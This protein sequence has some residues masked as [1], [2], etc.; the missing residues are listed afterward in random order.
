MGDLWHA[1]EI[2]EITSGV[3]LGCLDCWGSCGDYDAKQ[4]LPAD[5]EKSLSGKSLW[6]RQNQYLDRMGDKLIDSLLHLN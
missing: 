5:S 6:E 1:K 3:Q 2:S 4:P